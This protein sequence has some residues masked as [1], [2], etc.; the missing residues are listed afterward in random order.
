MT[1]WNILQKY[2]EVES[3]NNS[4]MNKNFK[5]LLFYP[6]EPL[7]GAAPSNLAILSAC[8]KNDG[9]DVK[10]FDCTIYKPKSTQTNDEMR[11]KLGHVKPT[12]IDEYFKAKDVDIYEDFVKIVEEYKP[13]LIGFS[14][15]DSTIPFSYTFIENIKN[16][17]IPIIFGG[18]GATFGY[19]KIL[20][21]NMVNFV[22][23]GEGEEALVELANK[24]Y[25]KEDC[26]NIKNIYLK[27][28]NGLIIKNKLRSL[29]DINKLPTPDFSIY[30]YYRF[31]RPFFGNVVR[32]MVIDTDRGCPFSCTYCAAP[33]LMN[34][35]KNENIGKYYRTKT[36]D[37]IFQ[38]I[39]SLV[40]QFDINHLLFVSETFT[41][42]P[43]KLFKKF[44]IRYKNEVGIPFSCQ[45][46]LDTLTEEKTKLLAEMGCK[47]V[48]VGLEHGSEKTRKDLLNKRLSNKQII[49]A[50]KEL[51]KYDITPGINNM[52]GLPD[53]RRSDVFETIKLNRKVSKILKGKHTLNVF[54]FI[55]FSG[56]KL[57]DIAMEKKYITGEE[58]ILISFFDK[59]LLDMPSMSKEEIYGLE[60]TFVLYV[61][62]PKSYYP[63][64]KVAEKNDS[65]GEEMFEKLM[66]I[67]HKLLNNK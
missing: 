21:S 37:K 66:V 10:L 50:F 3:K 32:T 23:I 58:E 59:S 52:I 46:R 45:S 44:A 29:I 15:L 13:N 27:N 48:A 42:L 11:A 30:E 60:K 9:F 18:V 8:L 47:T 53:E 17:N 22:C 57:R 40:K 6:N 12:K 14:V 4:K 51:A 19:E 35:S 16:K 34:L 7:L 1:N 56:T 61:M 67:K 26:S 64:I 54:T 65:K 2:T 28:K 36:F 63:D 31:Y 24:L 43:L 38:D 55:P 33:A 25:K 39:N 5:I 62:L 41:A 49:S 20:N